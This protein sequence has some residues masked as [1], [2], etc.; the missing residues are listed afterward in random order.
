MLAFSKDFIS[1]VDRPEAI[2]ILDPGL[3]SRHPTFA[4]RG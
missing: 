4:L 1:R 2:A 3:V